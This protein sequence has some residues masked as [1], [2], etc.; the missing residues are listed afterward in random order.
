MNKTLEMFEHLKRFWK[1]AISSACT[2]PK[3]EEE[4]GVYVKD[5]FR[6]YQQAKNEWGDNIDFL[7]YK[8]GEW[9]QRVYGFKPQISFKDN[10]PVFDD[11]RPERGDILKVRME[12]GVMTIWVF[13][14][15]ELVSDP[16]DMFF[17]DVVF[18]GYLTELEKLKE[19][20]NELRES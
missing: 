15:V 5:D 16:P 9:K 19:K 3:P 10:M 18:G 17:G 20:R 8:N 11:Q 13:T 7:D 6:I 14:D 12:S 4:E 1:K 2:R